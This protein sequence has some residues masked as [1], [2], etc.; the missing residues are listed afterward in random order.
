[1]RG[2]LAEGRTTLRHRGKTRGAIGRWGDRASLVLLFGAGG[3]GADRH[4]GRDPEFG[5][6]GPVDAG[7]SIGGGPVVAPHKGRDSEPPLD[8]LAVG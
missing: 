6:P 2:A 8:E 5:R 4:R 1:M 7:G 3:D